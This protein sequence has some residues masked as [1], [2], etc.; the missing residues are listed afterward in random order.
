MTA[1]GWAG[2]RERE[3]ERGRKE[4]RTMFTMSLNT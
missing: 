1:L 4:E 2:C 3:R